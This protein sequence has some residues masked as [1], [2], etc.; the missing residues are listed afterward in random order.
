MVGPIARYVLYVLCGSSKGFVVLGLS[1]HSWVLVAS[2]PHRQAHGRID[3]DPHKLA[4]LRAF[5]CDLNGMLR[6][7]KAR[8]VE[9]ALST[10][11]AFHRDVHTQLLVLYF[12]IL[13]ANREMK[14]EPDGLGDQVSLDGDSF[15]DSYGI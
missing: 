10:A 11:R 5:E 4:A 2:F 8:S 14:K 7:M 15:F 9:C 3:R 1:G 12:V 6:L 13:K